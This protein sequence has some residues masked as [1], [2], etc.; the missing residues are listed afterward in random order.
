MSSLVPHYWS[1]ARLQKREGGKRLTL[2]RWGWSDASPTDAQAHAE[3]R[4]E[5]AMVKALEYGWPNAPVPLARRERKQP[6]NGADGVP[7]REE[8]IE[9]RGE[10]VV[11]R[12]GYGARCL[13]VTDVMFVDV[14]TADLLRS[15]WWWKVL[16][17]VL[18]LLLGLAWW[19]HDMSV[20]D[21]ASRVVCAKPFHW[22]FWG[23]AW[24]AGVMF[25]LLRVLG[26]LAQQKVFQKTGGAVKHARRQ[27]QAAGGRW[28]VYQ[29]PAGA[30]L[31]A[32]HALFD[33]RADTTQALMEHMGAD[34]L[35]RQMCRHQGCFRARVSAKPWRMA[36]MERMRGPV[37]PVD[38]PQ[39]QDRRQT[40]VAA[41][42]DAQEGYAA[43]RYVGTEGSAPLN[44]RAADL[45]S[46]HDELSQARSL[47]P[48]A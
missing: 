8:I 30:R 34:P 17:A 44:D 20:C 25:G 29:T 35:Y 23:I 18:G 11:T 19:Q 31:L 28:A 27:A 14:D 41:Y 7:I 43:C 48:L 33:P 40:W 15:A 45:Q 1:E 24:R 26:A 3:Q 6:Y 38:D 12:N 21:A 39:K 37:W 9:E 2:R 5:A 16:A 46:W 47:K 13:N 42:E 32:L 36:G 4:V 10:D 22:V